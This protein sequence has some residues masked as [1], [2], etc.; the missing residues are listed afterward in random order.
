[1]LVKYQTFLLFFLW[2]ISQQQD[3]FFSGGT[4]SSADEMLNYLKAILSS[5]EIAPTPS[6]PAFPPA[7]PSS[8][9][10][11]ASGDPAPSSSGGESASGDPA[12]P[13][14]G[15][16]PASGDPAPSSSGGEPSSGDPAPSSSGGEPASGDPAPP[17]S[18]GEPTSGDP[19]PSSAG[20]DDGNMW[21]I[22]FGDFSG[23]PE[24]PPSPATVVNGGGAAAAAAGVETPVFATK[25]QVKNSKRAMARKKAYQ[26]RAAAPTPPTAPTPTTPSHPQKV[27]RVCRNRSR[28]H[29]GVSGRK[30]K[31]RG[32]RGLGWS[33]KCTRRRLKR[34]GSGW[35]VKKKRC[36]DGIWC[37]Q[38]FT[39]NVTEENYRDLRDQIRGGGALGKGMKAVSLIKGIY[40][41]T[42]GL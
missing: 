41:S 4:T 16:E 15:G 18:G 13:S 3:H 36:G 32:C 42:V 9:G 22:C 2:R 28:R 35:T 37:E 1:M 7:P 6:G 38:E 30:N 12:P 26:A 23:F 10:E 8:G 31:H 27:Y 5:T 29:V 21:N 25:R 11:P 33:G 20:D 40:F 24:V 14:S 39:F 19:A 17:S 34:K